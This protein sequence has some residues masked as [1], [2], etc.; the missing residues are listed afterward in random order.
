MMIYN[1]DIEDL[2]KSKS[3]ELFSNNS[4]FRI[5]ADCIYPFLEEECRLQNKDWDYTKDKH[6]RLL[7]IW[8]TIECRSKLR[9]RD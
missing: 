6:A 5:K 1:K 8:R 4:S 9:K 3:G 2:V 7:K